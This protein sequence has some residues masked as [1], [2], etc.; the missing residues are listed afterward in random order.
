VN[1]QRRNLAILRF[2]HLAISCDDEVIL[3]AAADLRIAAGG[4]HEKIG[5]AFGAQ[6]KMKI[7]GNSGGVEGRT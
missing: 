6:A 5:G 4:G 3:H 2:E 7:Q 1:P